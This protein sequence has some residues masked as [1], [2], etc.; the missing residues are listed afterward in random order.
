MDAKVS[1]LD[2]IW[3]ESIEYKRRTVGIAVTRLPLAQSLHQR[4]Y[5]SSTSDKT[6]ASVQHEQSVSHSVTAT[7][8]RIGYS[9]FIGRWERPFPFH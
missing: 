6:T 3:T 8:K 9:S 5:D 7:Q 1:V 4:W 2:H